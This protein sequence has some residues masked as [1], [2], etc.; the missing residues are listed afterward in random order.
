[1]RQRKLRNLDVKY[2]AY[3]DLIIHEPAEMRGSWGERSGGAP[4]YIE[5]G[6]GK[7]KFISEL[8]AREPQHFFVHIW[9]VASS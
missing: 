2:E 5:I 7:G 3:D 9:D 6:C 8:A 1:M 4:L